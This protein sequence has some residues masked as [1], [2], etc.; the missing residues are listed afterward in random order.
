M[1]E[2]NTEID[3]T[4][5]YFEDGLTLGLDPGYDAGHFNQSASLMSRLVAE[6]QGVG[7]A[8]NAMGIASL[9]DVVVPLVINRAAGVDFRISIDTFGLS[10]GT[11]VYLEDN[12]NGTMTLLNEQD[13]E[14][15]PANNLNGAGRFFIHFIE[16]SLSI[17]DEIKTNL[18]NVYKL[19]AH[20]FITI[21]GLANQSSQTTLR[22][23]DFL[24]KELVSKTFL[25]NINTQ[26][27][28][29]QGLTS[30]IYIIKLE[31]EN[32]VITKKLFIK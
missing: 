5:F 1:Y 27:I 4:R 14:L 2:G 13:F 11:N 19:R 3:Y 18:L 32:K 7:F 22:L 10:A 26:T 15:T 21:E 30:G 23:Y 31:S 24:G 28:S 12:Q 8:V 9:D 20:N 25:N 6:D 29:T 17:E 16:S